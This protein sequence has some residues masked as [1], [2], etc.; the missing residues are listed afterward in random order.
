LLIV[1]IQLH[2]IIDIMG[3]PYNGSRSE[4]SEAS[5]DELIRPVSRVLVVN[6]YPVTLL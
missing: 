4:L 5:S 6:L 1:L 2:C 3:V